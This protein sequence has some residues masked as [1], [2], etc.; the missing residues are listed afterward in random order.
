M[1]VTEITLFLIG[2]FFAGIINTLAGNGSSIT[3]SLLIFYGMPANI[4]NATNRIGALAQTFTAVVSLRK[5]EANKSLKK[6]ALWFLIPSIIGSAIGALLAVDIDEDLL[7]ILIGLFMFGLL[8]TLLYSPKKWMKGTNVSKSH[9]TT[10]NWIMIFFTAV[11]AGFIQMGLGI[12]VLSVL[13]LIAEYSLRDANIIK[14]ILAFIFVAP[15]FFIFLYS[16][17]MRWG[18][19]LVL[20]AGQTL[21]A[22]I[23]TRYVLDIPKANTYLR[24]L[25]IAILSI[26]SFSLLG[27]FEW[28][29]KLIG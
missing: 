10:L 29:Q 15:A 2:G 24:Y 18:P 12:I 13:V 26:S 20:A 21:G 1:T 17:D 23:G 22:I 4:A 7:R 14:L 9:K 19:G 27:I 25:L 11:Y 5:N 16:G 3:L 8:L 6:D 28:I